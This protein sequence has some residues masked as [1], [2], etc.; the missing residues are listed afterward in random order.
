MYD[1][2][3]HQALRDVR[4]LLSANLPSMRKL[5]DDRTVAC[6][7]T[8]VRAA[9]VQRAIERGNDTALSFATRREPRP[10]ETE[11]PPAAILNL[12]WGIMDERE[13]NRILAVLPHSHL[14]LWKKPP[15]R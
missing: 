1:G 2:A 6:L 7:R 14:R 11:L 12:L 4:D 15:A 5:P 8:I 13:L 3:I 10:S 9:S